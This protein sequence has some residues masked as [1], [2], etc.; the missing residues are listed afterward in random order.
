MVFFFSFFLSYLHSFLFLSIW[1]NLFLHF[2]LD[3]QEDGGIYS[4]SGNRFLNDF[5]H[6]GQKKEREVHSNLI[7]PYIKL[8]NKWIYEN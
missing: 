7:E 1:K 8:N 2:M 5:L 6:S 4:P 3:S